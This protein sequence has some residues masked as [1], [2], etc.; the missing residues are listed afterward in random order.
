VKDARTFNNHGGLEGK[1]RRDHAVY[2]ACGTH[3]GWQSLMPR[4]VT[5]NE[6]RHCIQVSGG[7]T[8]TS[9]SGKKYEMKT[10]DRLRSSEFGRGAP[11]RGYLEAVLSTLP[12]SNFPHARQNVRSVLYVPIVLRWSRTTSS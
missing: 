5:Q 11:V 2:F 3:R 9:K 12:S 1:R 10:V 8:P 4:V 7:I 6:V